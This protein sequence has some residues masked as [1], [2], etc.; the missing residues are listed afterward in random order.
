[1][2]IPLP[3]HIFIHFS[4]AVLTGYFCGKYFKN[5]FLGIIAGVLGGF[6]IDFDHILEY[7][8]V[9]DWHFN[10]V[11]FFE[12]R[13]FLY[14]EKIHLWFHAWEYFPLLLLL[15]YFLRKY[16]KLKIFLITLAI[17]GAVHLLSDS[18]INIVPPKFYTLSYRASQDFSMKNLSSEEIYQLNMELK[19]NLGIE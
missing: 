7:L 18:V 19:E 4:M 12:G 11:H 6:L 3:L 9:Y 5:I 10:L 8:L 13:Q 1:M 15:A 17:A 16:K 2:D 14:S